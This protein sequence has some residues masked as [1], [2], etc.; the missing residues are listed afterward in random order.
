MVSLK[1]CRTSEVT[2]CF[3]NVS[4]LEAVI[5][6]WNDYLERKNQLDQWL[7]S[8]DH[9]LE[10]PLELQSGLKEKFSQLDCFQA[11]VSEVED[12]SNDLHQLTEKARELHDKTED[13]SFREAAQEELK[14]QLSD[15]TTVV[16]V[17]V[18]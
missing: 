12:H 14:T 13:S 17:N 18:L 5:H 9:K 15:I 6:Q 8:V 3:F 1:L 7:E 2:V 11:I 10:Q 4:L 16:K